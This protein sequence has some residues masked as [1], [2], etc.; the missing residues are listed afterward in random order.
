MGNLYCLFDLLIVV[1]WQA[2]WNGLACQAPG[3]CVFEI[4]WFDNS[5]AE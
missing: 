2:A 3:A 5:E 4:E 1:C